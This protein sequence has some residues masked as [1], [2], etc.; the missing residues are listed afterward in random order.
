MV[1]HDGP[2]WPISDHYFLDL[3]GLKHF[4]QFRI[5]EVAKTQYLVIVW[6][7]TGMGYY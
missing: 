5:T 6:I 3:R 4:H 1:A 2:G 7:I